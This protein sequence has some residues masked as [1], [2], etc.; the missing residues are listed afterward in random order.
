M[1]VFYIKSFLDMTQKIRYIGGCYLPI[2]TFMFVIMIIVV[3]NIFDE[4]EFRTNFQSARC[5]RE[6][7]T[8]LIL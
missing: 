8:F 1:L 2:K 6:C 5:H 3:T 7:L 4:S